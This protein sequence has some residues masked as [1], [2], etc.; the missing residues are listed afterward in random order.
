MYASMRNSR[1]LR[2]GI[3]TKLIIVRTFTHV[4]MRNVCHKL[5]WKVRRTTP[6]LLRFESKT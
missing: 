2:I 1:A 4:G 5:T 3:E 6:E